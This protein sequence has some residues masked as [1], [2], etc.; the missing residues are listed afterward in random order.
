MFEAQHTTI[1]IECIAVPPNNQ[2]ERTCQPGIPLAKRRARGMP[3]R[4]AAHLRR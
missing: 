4:H 3:G 1:S 2:M